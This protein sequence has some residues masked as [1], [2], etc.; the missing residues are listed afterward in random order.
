MTRLRKITP[1]N[2]PKAEQVTV[3][4]LVISGGRWCWSYTIDQEIPF[5]FIELDR[6]NGES[7]EKIKIRGI[8]EWAMQHKN[9]E[10]LEPGSCPD[11]VIGIDWIK[12]CLE[13]AGYKVREDRGLHT[14]LV[15]EIG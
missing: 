10:K 3:F 9:F 8:I 1:K 6:L 12:A 15:I 11:G 2:S 14:Y 7:F 5:N 4:G 13:K